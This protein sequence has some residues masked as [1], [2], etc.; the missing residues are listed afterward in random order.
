M[1]TP[2]CSKK[3]K[4]RTALGILILYSANRRQ[5]VISLETIIV[6]NEM[7]GADKNVQFTYHVCRFPLLVHSC[8]NPCFEKSLL[9]AKACYILNLSRFITSSCRRVEVTRFE[10]SFGVLVS[11]FICRHC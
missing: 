7:S 8:S 2:N 9:I 6:G 10:V 1:H 3:T 5:V 11:L 4:V